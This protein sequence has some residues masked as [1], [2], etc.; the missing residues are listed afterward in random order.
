MPCPHP[1]S[2]SIPEEKIVASVPVKRKPMGTVIPGRP[3]TYRFVK[4][5]DYYADYKESVFAITQK[6]AGWDCMRHYEI[7]A[8]GCIPYFTDIA[9]CPTKT[10]T[11]FP[12]QLV[13][14]AMAQINRFYSISLPLPPRLI[15]PPDETLLTSLAEKLLDYTRN[16]LTCR[17]AAQY[18]LRTIQKPSVT[19]VLYLIGDPNPD[20]MMMMN[21]IGFKQLLGKQCH[22][23]PCLHYLYTDT[24]MDVQGLYGR[25]M[26]YTRVLDRTL[27]YDAKRDDTLTDDISKHRYD[28][29][30]YGSIHRGLPF[31]NYVRQFYTPEEIVFICG[32]DLHECEFVKW[33]FP[34]LFVRELS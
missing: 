31:L 3:E 24:K 19:S 29:V 1:I 26:S 4:E 21:C 13:L 7:L 11:N 33:G 30:V 32:E 34:N 20:Y 14:D 28:I 16:H 17:A 2:F 12:K 8:C 22:E 5:A 25:G 15:T 6:K 10:M 18:I 27:C 23:W 9:Q